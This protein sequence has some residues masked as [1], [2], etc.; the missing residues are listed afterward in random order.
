MHE[1]IAAIKSSSA[2]SYKLKS[3]RYRDVSRYFSITIIP[4]TLDGY[5]TLIIANSVLSGALLAIYRSHIQR[6]LVE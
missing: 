2:L 5:G 6:S 1:K 4:L 3:A